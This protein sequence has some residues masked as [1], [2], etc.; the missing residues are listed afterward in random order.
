MRSLKSQPIVS[1][2]LVA[3]NVIVFIL[4]S[5][6]GRQLYLMG[7]LDVY[8]VLVQ[9][10]FGRIVWA[11]FLHMDISHLTS[12]MFILFFLGTMIERELGHIRYALLYFLSG[13]GGNVIS[14]LVKL[15]VN[16]LSASLG[17]SGAVFGLDG[18][19][20]AMVFFWGRKMEHV[21]PVRVLLMVFCSLYS[22]FQGDN[23]DNAAH[24]GGLL[25]GFCIAG[26][27]CMIRHLKH[28]RQKDD[29]EK[30]CE[31]WL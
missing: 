6:T 9:K 3:V 12:N 13:I 4:C 23:I 10:E 24:V 7:R 30:E 14:L 21:T 1:G 15:A 18:A 29:V 5:I 16:E 25:T 11:M 20:L 2:V 26:I 22:G 28:R 19:L 17:A 27:M 31:V 8:D